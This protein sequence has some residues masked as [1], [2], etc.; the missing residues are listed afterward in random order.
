ML[1]PVFLSVWLGCGL[2]AEQGVP[3]EQINADM[4]DNTI[5]VK[6]ELSSSGIENWEFTTDFL[7]CFAPVNEETKV[8]ESNAEI[9]IN[10][11]SSKYPTDSGITKVMS[12]KILLR[13][14][15][16]NGKWLLEGIEPKDALTAVLEMDKA[17]EFSRSSAPLCRHFSY[18]EE[19]R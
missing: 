9:V 17:I 11:N 5:Q 16:E 13:Y 15:N 14:K 2:I 4:H 10:V 18:E 12:G 6:N 8:T 19:R 3:K 7:R 1:L